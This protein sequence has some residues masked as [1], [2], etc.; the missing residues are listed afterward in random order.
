MTA[1]LIA[2]LSLAVLGIPIALAVDRRARGPLLD[3]NGVPVWQRDDVL[4]AA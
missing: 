1:T 3:R 4:R 2:I